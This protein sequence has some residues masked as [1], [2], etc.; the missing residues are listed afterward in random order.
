M[1]K[2]LSIDDNENAVIE[3]DAED[4]C[5]LINL[6]ENYQTEWHNEVVADPTDAKEMMKDVYD[7]WTQKLIDIFKQGLKE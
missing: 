4:R 7:N 3:L 6:L 2:L 1:A 5:L